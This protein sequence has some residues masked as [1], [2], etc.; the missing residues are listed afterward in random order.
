MN[1]L[2]LVSMFRMLL[3]VSF[4]T[5]HKLLGLDRISERIWM[6]CACEQIIYPSLSLVLNYAFIQSVLDKIA[7][8]IDGFQ[9]QPG[10]KRFWKHVKRQ[11]MISDLKKELDVALS[12]FQVCAICSILS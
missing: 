7:G 6:N 4:S 8:D 12:H 9:K 2:N 10:R 3:L 5:W 1:G 11:D